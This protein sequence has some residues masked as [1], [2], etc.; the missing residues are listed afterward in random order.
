MKN[1]RLEELKD[2]LRID[3]DEEDKIL[4]SFLLSAKQFLLNA[5]IKENEE[6]ALYNLAINILVCG[7][8]DD[9]N[10]T[11]PSAKNTSAFALK[12]IITQLKC[13]QGRD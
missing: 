9:R 7:W 8:Y 11:N 2:F 12:S 5:G 6:N 4:S 3:T 13:C 10:P 1:T